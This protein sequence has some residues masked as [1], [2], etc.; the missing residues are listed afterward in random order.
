M[1]I[2]R[3]MGWL[4]AVIVF[5]F[6]FAGNLICNSIYGDGYYDNHK[7][8][9]CLALALSAIPIWFLGRYL[10]TKSDRIVIDKATGKEMAMNQ[11]R[12]ALFFIPMDYWAPI[13]LVIAVATFFV[14]QKPI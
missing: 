8:P 9:L 1:I 6:S 7:G 12:H 10:R 5:G 13:L 4:V 3:G 11:S 2:W 14:Q